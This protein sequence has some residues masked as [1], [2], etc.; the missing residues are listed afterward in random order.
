MHRA[1]WG[2]EWIAFR[3]LGKTQSIHCYCGSN[4]GTNDLDL[5]QF[6]RVICGHEPAHRRRPGVRV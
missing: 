2:K 1:V 6:A 4:P 3:E 5:T